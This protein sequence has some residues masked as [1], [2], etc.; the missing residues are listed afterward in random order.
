MQTINIAHLIEKNSIT[1]LSKD[2]ENRLINKI[3]L[4]FTENQQQIFVAS[5]YTYLNYDSKKDFVIDFDS[6]WKWLGFTRKDNAKRL[7]D[8]FFVVN[9]DYKIEELAPHLGGASFEP[10][11][12]GQNKETILLTVNTFKKFC[13]KAGTKK[14]DEIHDYFIKLEELLQETINEETNELRLQLEKKDYLLEK[15]VI[16]LENEVKTKERYEKNLM[17]MTEKHTRLEENHKRILYKNKRHQLKKGPCLYLLHNPDIPETKQIVKFG[18]TSNLN[19]RRS[20]YNTYFE[21]Q[22]LYV[23]F[24]NNN[25][26]LEDILKV[27]YRDNI[28]DHSDEWTV[29]IDY[30]EIIDFLEKTAKDINVD[31]TG[32]LN[33]KEIEGD[34]DEKRNE[35]EEANTSFDD[36]D[37]IE[38]EEES[39]ATF[40]DDN[41]ELG[42]EEEENVVMKK[43]TK[44]LSV[45]NKTKCFN[46]D[47][48]KKDGYHGCC[49][50]CEK[51]AKQS[52]KNK[53]EKEFVA[54]TEKQCV[55]CNTVKDISKFSK[56]LYNKDGY[57]NNCLD[58]A[59]EI[60]NKARL[61]DKNDN[62]RYKCGN[63]DKDY[64]RKDSL[65]KH[66]K[67]CGKKE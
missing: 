44:C 4:N 62:I 40:K 25:K 45:Q 51:I 58:C 31:F 16:H 18:T 36:D 12:G 26:L 47:K 14:A 61:R 35:K 22:F 59:Q 54:L 64:A 65:L 37:N 39:I 53:K 66:S 49:K 50:I 7:L 23:M 9:I 41:S 21:P 42:L 19:I 46:K 38:V 27:K 57:V 63:C 56:H 43:C 2:Y 10:S 30:R 55:L 1:R 34:E 20:T 24:T 33:I 15:T 8:K 29:S 67:L 32:H 6:V 11:H 28:K 3:K 17:E 5:F 48:S 60:T 13:M 52:Y